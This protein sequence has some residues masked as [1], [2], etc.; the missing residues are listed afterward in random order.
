MLKKNK[1]LIIG[2]VLGALLFTI[3]PVNATVQEYILKTSPDKFIVD[4]EEIV[5]EKLPMLKYGGY[6]YIP[7]GTFREICDKIG[8][9]FE[10]VGEKKEIRIDTGKN[11]SF[12]PAERRGEE[13]ENIEYI[14][15]DGYE[16]LV[17]DGVEYITYHEAHKKFPEE[18]V[19]AALPDKTLNFVHQKNKDK[20]GRVEKETIF[21]RDVP[22]KIV[23]NMTCIE[24]EYFSTNILPLVK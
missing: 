17:V 8:V 11:V 3:I 15:K 2:F 23:G 5:N 10:W 19:I 9:G 7:A 14:E 20:F 18:Y 6:N 22:Y 4:G 1:Q 16:L 21:I 13:M 12:S 24:Y